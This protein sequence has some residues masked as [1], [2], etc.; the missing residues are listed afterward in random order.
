MLKKRLIASL[1]VRQGIVVQSVGFETYLP[2]GKPDIAVEY[3]SRWGI[4]EIVLLDMDATAEGR[5][6][7]FGMVAS[8]SKKCFVP[9]TVGGGVHT[10]ADIKRLIREGADKVS[11]HTAA[12]KTPDLIQEAANVFGNQCIVVSVDV[13]KHA[14]GR[15]EVF[16]NSGKTPTGLSPVDMAK[17]AERYGAGE[18]LLNSID[19]DGSKAGYDVELIRQVSAAVTIPVIALGGAGHPSHFLEGLTKANATA[20]AAGNYFH[21][22]EHS[23]IVTKQY[24]NQLRPHDVRLDTFAT[25]D[26]FNTDPQGRVAR[27]T[28]D[29]FHKMRF[30]FQPDEV[31]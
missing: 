11:L 25:Y 20:V 13:R 10:M 22:T 4:D 8:V 31:V 6:P 9:L 23:P 12:F 29:Y 30:E 24:V 5:G 18:I 19:R 26:G 27:A 21:Y 28:D 3:L 1:I 2:V 7:R 16:I 15:Y 17:K 14:D